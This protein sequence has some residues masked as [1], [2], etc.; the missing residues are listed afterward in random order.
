M[1]CAASSSPTS[2]KARRGPPLQREPSD[3]R[4]DAA[5]VADGTWH[6]AAATYD[7]ATW[8]LYLDGAFVGSLA[9]GQPPNAPTTRSPRSVAL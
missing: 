5:I 3:H 8:N 4:D 9:V 7:G 1:P 2:K 6:H